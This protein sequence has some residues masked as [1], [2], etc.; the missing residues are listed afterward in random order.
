MFIGNLLPPSPDCT[1]VLFARVPFTA[2]TQFANFLAVARQPATR[3]P[4]KHKSGRAVLPSRIVV[5]VG[6]EKP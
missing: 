1:Q 2:P 6:D 3:Q 4:A 5:L